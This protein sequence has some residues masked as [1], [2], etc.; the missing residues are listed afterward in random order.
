MV[1]SSGVQQGIEKADSRSKP[2][3]LRFMVTAAA[4][5]MT[6]SQGNMTWAGYSSSKRR[7][8]RS[9]EAP[10][11]SLRR[12]SPGDSSETAL[13]VEGMKA[14]LTGLSTLVATVQKEKSGQ[15]FLLG[16][17]YGSVADTGDTRA[18]HS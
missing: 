3:R 17:K 8:F 5:V 4:S 2:Q 7:N 18:S 14:S 6:P 1:N 15:G 12:A 10:T 13:T 9:S 16:L 11:V